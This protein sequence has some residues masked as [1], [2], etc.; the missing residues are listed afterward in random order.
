MKTMNIHLAV[1]ML[2]SLLAVSCE[3]EI[4]FNGEETS[5]LLVVNS[6]FTP[7]SLVK[8]HV[9]KSKFFLKDDS[10]FD[11]VNNAV[12][13]LWINDVKIEKL[14]SIGEGYYLG[15]Y[16]PSVNNRIRITAE[17][18]DFSQVSGTTEIIRPVNILSVDTTSRMLESTPITIVSSKPTGGLKID[19]IGKINTK[20]LNFKVNFMDLPNVKNFYRLMVTVRQY[21][22]DGTN[23]DAPFYF[24]SE[25]LVFGKNSERGIFNEGSNND[26]FVFTDE[27]F[28]SKKYGL[29]FYSNF[30]EYIYFNEVVNRIDNPKFDF[31][32]PIKSELHINIQSISKSY[33]MF[34]K[35]RVANLT[36]NEFF[37]E[38]VQIYS[39]VIGGIGIIGSYT[40]SLYSIDIPLTVEQKYY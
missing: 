18:T 14:K 1:L 5:P 4:K 15:T 23:K 6:F 37:S 13:N 20:Q 10:S 19:T 22:A 27:L 3:N 38:P 21:F 40:N 34:A 31:N 39:N 28:E 8:V 2:I 32:T 24:Y 35:S 12:V 9:S 26:Y 29:K 30:Y 36:V 33:F 7:D 11:V 17:N 25:D 16:M